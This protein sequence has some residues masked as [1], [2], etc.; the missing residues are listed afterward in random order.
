MKMIYKLLLAVALFCSATWQMVAQTYIVPPTDGSYFYIQFSRGANLVLESQGSGTLNPDGTIVTGTNYLK[1]AILTIGKPSQLWKA[2]VNGDGY[3]FIS[4]QLDVDGQTQLQIA[5]DPNGPDN[6]RFAVVPYSN[7]S[8]PLYTTTD[9]ITGE[10]AYL[11]ACAIVTD[12]TSGNGMNP[13]GGSVA[14]K[15]IGVYNKNDGGSALRFVLSKSFLKEKIDAVKAATLDP[16]TRSAEVQAAMQTALNAAQAVYADPNSTNEQL[17][18]AIETL[19]LAFVEYDAVLGPPTDGTYFYIKF[20]RGTNLVVENMGNGNQLQTSTLE[21]GKES[22]LWRAE[23][24]PEHPGAVIFVSKEYNTD[25]LGY[26]QMSWDATAARYIAAPYTGFNGFYSTTRG[27]TVNTNFLPASVIMRTVSASEAMNPFGGSDPGKTLGEWN[28]TD[29]GNALIYVPES[30]VKNGLKSTI[31]EAN[32]LLQCASTNPGSPS[33]D[34]QGILR[35][36]I[37]SAKTVFDNANSTPEEF[38]A[39]ANALAA[40]IPVY[41]AAQPIAVPV[42]SS[43]DATSEKWYFLQGTRPANTYLTSTGAGANLWAKTAIPDDTQL[44]KIVPNTNPLGDNLGYALVNKKTGEYLN[45]DSV[46]N[47]ATNTTPNIPVTNLVFNMSTM[48]T[49][50]VAQFWIENTGTTPDDASLC[51]FR[52]HSGENGNILNW[53]GNR[54]DNSSWL[55][56]DYSLSLKGFLKDAIKNVKSIVD[57]PPAHVGTALGQYPADAKSGLSTAITTA[58]AVYDNA[59]ATDAEVRAAIDNLNIAITIYNGRKGDA[60]ISTAANPR[61]FVI[62]NLNRTDV[63]T[64]EKNQVITSH[65]LTEAKGLSCEARANTNEQLWR[66]EASAT[67]GVKIINAAK[68]DSAIVES[69]YNV[70]QKL[71]TVAEASGYVIDSLGVGVKLTSAIGNQLHDTGAGMLFTWNDAAGTGSNWAIEERTSPLFVAQNFTFDAISEKLSTDLPFDLVAN[72]NVP[73]GAITFTSSDVTVATVEGSRLTIV[74]PGTAVI[75]ASNSGNDTYARASVQHTLI[76]H[77]PDGLNDVNDGI[78]VSAKNK[79]IVVVGTDAPVKVFTI[80]GVEVNA[81]RT[82]IPGI[83]IVKVAGK[84]VKVNVR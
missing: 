40:A 37:V 65:G 31:E 76:V 66:F 55:L 15:E 36:A 5:F 19:N 26:L 77:L 62:R 82:L 35:E 27:I 69:G 45:T 41:K 81:K 57:A 14:G 30:E 59:T 20:K 8:T 34:D 67:G 80:T 28:K 3:T 56:M 4:Q 78:S 48:K 23:K 58:Q 73:D 13:W 17:S 79:Q 22:Q 21:W 11:P 10:A 16:G 24:D 61:W 43:A 74:G 33:M 32:F 72:T 25:I 39:A 83:Y 12:L 29:D 70:Q 50:G 54:T 38:A 18:S 60:V 53:T 2:E 52:L 68:P 44:W 64:A 47:M 42:V 51:Y 84:T 63:A 6:G 1:S 71:G 9:G 75:T 49:N 46:S 7:Q